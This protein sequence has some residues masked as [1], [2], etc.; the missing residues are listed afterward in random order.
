MQPRSSPRLGLDIDLSEFAASDHPV[1]SPG[2]RAPAPAASS[3]TRSHKE[4]T[5]FDSL[6]DFDD[7]DTGFRP[8]DMGRS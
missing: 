1:T 7:Y 5:V 8:D 3:T 6:V 2:V 4:P